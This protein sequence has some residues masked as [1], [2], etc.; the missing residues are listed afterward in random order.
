VDLPHVGSIEFKGETQNLYR[1]SAAHL[2]E[3]SPTWT[4]RSSSMSSRRWRVATAG[5]L[6]CHLDDNRDARLTET[7]V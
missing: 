3:K 5:A 1:R 7:M 6:A 4:H 2:V